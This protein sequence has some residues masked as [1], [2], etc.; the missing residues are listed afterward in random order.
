MEFEEKLEKYQKDVNDYLN[1][2]I[3]SEHRYIGT[4]LNSMRYSLFAGGKRLRPILMLGT[5]EI[6]NCPSK[7]VMPYAAAIEMIHTYSLIHD[8]LPGMDN[9]N[10]RRGKPTNHKVYGTGMAILAGDGLLNFAYEHMLEFACKNKDCKYI[11]AALEI[12][13][14]AG[15]YG[16]VGGQAVDI[17]NSGKSISR[18]LMDFMHENKTGALIKAAVRSAAIISGANVDDLKR[19]SDY[20]SDLGLA[21]QIIDDILDITGDEKRLGKKTGSD[22]ANNKAT[23]VSMYGVEKSRSIAIEL[24]QDAIC[25]LEYYNQRAEF[26]SKLTGYLLNRD[27]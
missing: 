21:F 12:A 10:Y 24:T 26:L 22:T 9:D 6:F 18:E 2:S 13:H 4:V 27:F 15:I 5:A 11:Q 16:M 19:L 25:I 1:A 23:Y 14:G 3:P 20:G 7:Y 8:D 17:E